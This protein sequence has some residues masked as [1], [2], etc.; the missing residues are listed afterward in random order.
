[1]VSIVD[2]FFV[3]VVP[4]LA[5]VRPAYSTLLLLLTRVASC[6]GAASRGSHRCLVDCAPTTIIVAVRVE[7][8]LAKGTA[9]KGAGA[10]GMSCSEWA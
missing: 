8:S 3:V 7:D 10:K 2:R 4:A 6:K 1:M 9:S 5:A